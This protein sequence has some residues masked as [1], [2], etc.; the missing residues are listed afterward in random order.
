MIERLVRPRS[1]GPAPSAHAFDALVLAAAGGLLRVGIAVWAW[2]RFPPVGDGH[3]YD[4]I[5]RRLVA[6]LGYTWAW[7]DGSV[8]YAAHYPIGYPAFLAALYWVFGTSLGAAA[9]GNAIVGAAGVFATHRIAHRGGSRF[10]SGVAGAL[11]A[12]HPGLVL[13]TPAL[14]TEGFTAALV[15]VAMWLAIRASERPRLL[16]LVLVGASIAAATYV[17]PQAIV[18]SILLPATLAWSSRPR[19]C[20]VLLGSTAIVAATA[21]LFVAPWTLRNFARMNTVSL[22]SVNDGWNLL[23]GTDPEAHGTWAPVKVPDACR[24]VDDEAMKNDC[25]GRAARAEIRRAPLRWLALAPEKLGATFNYAGAGPWYLHEA[26]PLIVGAG[27]KRVLAALEIVFERVA[28]IL[29]LVAV[30]RAS[31]RL[32]RRTRRITQALALLGIAFVLTPMAAYVGVLALAASLGITTFAARR[33]PVPAMSLG[34]VHLA[35][36]A[37]IHV[38]FFG[39]GRYSVVVFPIV[40]GVAAFA[41]ARR[42]VASRAF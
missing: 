7:P 27:M 20:R 6:G 4:A 36:T 41:F 18:L 40:C 10:A 35:S 21:L 33:P 3:Y 24:D 12:I 13:Y 23:I 32:R 16:R 11:V 22:V 34:F 17:R 1:E 15:A 14:M 28:W 9:L 8:T 37:A 31:P 2:D 30:L 42:F 19:S 29:A 26:N 39:A 5:A 25:F 38:V